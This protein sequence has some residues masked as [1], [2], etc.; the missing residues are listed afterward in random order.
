MRRTTFKFAASFA[1]LFLCQSAEARGHHSSY[2]H[3]NS[4]GHVSYYHG[5][6]GGRH[7]AAIHTSIP[8]SAPT[9]RPH[10]YL[11]R[12]TCYGANGPHYCYKYPSNHIRLHEGGYLP[13]APP[14]STVDTPVPNAADEIQHLARELG[15]AAAARVGPCNEPNEMFE[16]VFNGMMT[17]P[18]THAMSAL[19][20]SMV[21]PFSEGLHSP[22]VRKK[23]CPETKDN[24]GK[25]TVRFYS[26]FYLEDGHPARIY[27]VRLGAARYERLCSSAAIREEGDRVSTEMLAKSGVTPD[28]LPTIDAKVSEQYAKSGDLGCITAARIARW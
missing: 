11:Y 7:H 18:S 6:G 5:H 17:D 28:L 14:A 25:A 4:R 9:D 21:E 23:S 15:A 3:I 26:A 22:P 19:G 10:K 13:D 8:I 24:F 12:Y 27:A 2:R 16:Q 20:E 1:F